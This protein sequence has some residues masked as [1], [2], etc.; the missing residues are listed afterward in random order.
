VSSMNSVPYPSGR[1]APPSPLSRDAFGW[2]ENMDTMTGASRE[3]SPTAKADRS[4]AQS[5]RSLLMR[6]SVNAN[7]R[8]GKGSPSP[9]LGS[10][11]DS[12]S[13]SGA[14]AAAV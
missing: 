1:P 7:R 5:A 6:L 12:G 10:S 8:G 13:G 2:R 9:R 14:G 3:D 11:P 4:H